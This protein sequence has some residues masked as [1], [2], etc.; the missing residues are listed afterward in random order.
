[1]Y[2]FRI[3]NFAQQTPQP[4]A[5]KLACLTKSIFIFLYIVY[6]IIVS[7]FIFLLNTNSEECGQSFLNSSQ[8]IYKY[9]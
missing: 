2:L 1:M 8:F 3:I 6:S 7:R 9:V 4:A 5:I